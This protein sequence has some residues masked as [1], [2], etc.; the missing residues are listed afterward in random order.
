ME[1]T[2]FAIAT[3][4]S[5][6]ITVLPMWRHEAWWIRGLDFPRVQFMT[7]IGVILLLALWRLDLSQASNL[8]LLAIN[9]ACLLYHGWWIL[10]YTRLHPVEVKSA[11][12]GQ[13]QH[14][15]KIL[16]SNV[17]AT[18]KHAAC[19]IDLVRQH[20]PDIL[21]TLESTHWW[22]QQLA[23]LEADYPYTIK[24]PLE[25]LYGMH[26]Y[27]RLPLENSTKEYLVQ[28]DV[29]SMHCLVRLACGAKVR[30]H[31]IHPAPPSPTEN[32]ESTER[33][34]ELL[35]VARNVANARM[36][37]IV[38]GDLNDVAWST[39]T[40]LFR[41]ISGLLDPRIGRGMFNTFHAE[42]WFIRWPLDHLFHSHHFR[43]LKLQRL[44]LTGSDHFALLTCL[45]FNPNKENG[46]NELPVDADDKQLANEKMAKKNI[47][48]SDVPN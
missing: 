33:D 46:H 10:P 42:H 38:A 15:L 8:G 45:S 27:S 30:V 44:K 41:K 22:Q 47:S 9:L 17:L 39:T 43:V 25:N 11:S 4:I 12:V 29:P 14:P 35:A 20:N 32:D 40:R 24:C 2:L 19:L 48:K 6:A 23:E 13:A 16:S 37:V 21:V 1:W 31:L 5:T 34:A 7:V 28:D 18:N 3:L 26:V 36:P